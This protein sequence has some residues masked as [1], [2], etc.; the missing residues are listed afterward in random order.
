MQNHEAESI[1]A[2]FAHGGKASLLRLKSQDYTYVLLFGTRIFSP[3][4]SNQGKNFP[5]ATHRLMMKS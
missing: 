5:K 2:L 3:G 1:T 4:L